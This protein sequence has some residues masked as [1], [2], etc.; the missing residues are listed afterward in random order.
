MLFGAF[1]YVAVIGSRATEKQLDTAYLFEGEVPAEQEVADWMS[2]AQV[3]LSTMF[4]AGRLRQAWRRFGA[5]PETRDGV[6]GICFR[7]WAPNAERAS[8][9]GDFNAWDGRVHQM[10]TLGASGVWELFI[11][12]LRPGALYRF[13]LRLR[14]GAI[15]LNATD[16]THLI[17]IAGSLGLAVGGGAGGGIGRAL[18]LRS[19]V[20]GSECEQPAFG[21]LGTMKAD[22]WI[23][24]KN[25]G[26]PACRFGAEQE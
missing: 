6:A 25:C 22:W 26:R 15:K 17:A 4:N 7:V 23:V 20:I 11:P 12:D 18:V 1:L 2:A 3:E 14:G 5:V 19:E 8:V 9:V 21:P 24:S 10:A 13:E 16:S